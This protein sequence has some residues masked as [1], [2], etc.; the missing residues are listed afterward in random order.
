MRGRGTFPNLFPS[1]DGFCNMSLH[2]SYTDLER[3][4]RRL[5]PCR[6]DIVSERFLRLSEHNHHL[7][8]VKKL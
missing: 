6:A 5:Y 7:H 2:F 3:V 8:R 1:R 4:V